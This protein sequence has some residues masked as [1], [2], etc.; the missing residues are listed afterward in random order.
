LRSAADGLAGARGGT[1]FAG[2][3]D[4]LSGFEGPLSDRGCAPCGSEKS[5]PVVS[6]ATALLLGMRVAV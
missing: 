3:A 5:R 6:S 2:V 4:P 1:R